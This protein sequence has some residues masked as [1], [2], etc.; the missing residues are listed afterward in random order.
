MNKEVLQSFV[1]KVVKVNRGGPES[2]VGKL[3]GVGED[4]FTI[5]TE[6]DGVVYYQTHHI[7]SL[8][9]NAKK[10]IEFNVE[11]LEELEYMSAPTLSAVLE[12]IKYSW[13]KIN[14]GGKD[15]I[16]G[17]LESSNDDFITVVFNEEVIRLSM[18][19]I[20]SISYGKK[21]EKAKQENEEANKEKSKNKNKNEK[22][23][24]SKEG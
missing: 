21:I 22:E 7:K 24:K 2:R 9:E 13:V 18:F 6:Q 1:G 19:H 4:H 23:D 3:L 20:Q 10:G 5:L 15:S 12:S 17:V 11:I 14:R 8:T 16:E